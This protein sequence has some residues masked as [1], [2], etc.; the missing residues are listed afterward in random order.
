MCDNKLQSSHYEAI[1][2]VHKKMHEHGIP[3]WRTWRAGW[4]DCPPAFPL[5]PED[6]LRIPGKHGSIYFDANLREGA[7]MLD[8]S[9]DI[10]SLSNFKRNTAEF[11]RQM[12]QTG[13]PVI[14]TVNG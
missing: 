1:A 14:L 6:Y 9:R 13:H 2:A 10:N 12:K 3:H 7:A 11:I 4:T 8:I 5:N